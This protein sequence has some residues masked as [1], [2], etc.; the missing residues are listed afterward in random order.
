MLPPDEPARAR[1]PRTLNVTE[2]VSFLGLLNRRLRIADASPAVNALSAPS[3]PLKSQTAPTPVPPLS[4]F[5]T[6]TVPLAEVI[7]ASSSRKGEK[8][9]CDEMFLILRS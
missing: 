1:L 2:N 3:F 7:L 6:V 5:A 9:V 4:A 8:I